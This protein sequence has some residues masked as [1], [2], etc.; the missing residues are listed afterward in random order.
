MGQNLYIPLK[1]TTFATIH[2]IGQTNN[3]TTENHKINYESGK[4]CSR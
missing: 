3:E 1:T 4:C 2:Q